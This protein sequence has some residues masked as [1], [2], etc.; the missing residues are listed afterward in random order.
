MDDLAGMYEE[1]GNLTE[2]GNI[3]EE[4]LANWAVLGDE[5]LSKFSLIFDLARMYRQQGRLK[6]AAE[7]LARRGNLWG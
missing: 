4:T 1:Q 2:A 7:M 3:L 5:S 6:I